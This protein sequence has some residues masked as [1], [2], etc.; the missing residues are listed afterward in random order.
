MTLLEDL[1]NMI[2]F[3]F[4]LDD[5]DAE[6]LSDIIRLQIDRN[7]MRIIDCIADGDNELID[8]YKRDNEYVK[9]L[10]S[11]VFKKGNENV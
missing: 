4:E 3:N 7:N 11:K 1:R 10:L 2:K 9:Y 5:I 8:Y 6:N